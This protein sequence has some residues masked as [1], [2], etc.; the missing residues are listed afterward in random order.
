MKYVGTSIVTVVN[1]LT[2]AVIAMK[3]MISSNKL[4]AWLTKQY[5]SYI[6]TFLIIPISQQ[7]T[8][9]THTEVVHCQ[10][11]LLGIF[12]SYLWPLKDP[13][14]TLGVTKLLVSP[15]TSVSPFGH[16]FHVVLSG[17][18]QSWSTS[19]SATTTKLLLLVLLLEPLTQ[20]SQSIPVWHINIFLQHFPRLFSTHL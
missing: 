6:K 2:A 3:L 15:L 12:H 11:V 20:N 4:L 5:L 18:F 14:S 10:E 13:G 17:P 1:G 9:T 16:S 7:C 19:I 8:L